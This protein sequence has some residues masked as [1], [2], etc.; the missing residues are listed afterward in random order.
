MVGGC[1]RSGLTGQAVELGAEFVHGRPEELLALIAEAGAD[2][3][4]AWWGAGELLR[5][6]G[7]GG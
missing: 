3:G 5:T 4:G 6:G 2:G 7:L 1:G